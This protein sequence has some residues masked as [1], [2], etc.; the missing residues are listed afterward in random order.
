L[1]SVEFLQIIKRHLLPGGIYYFNTTES[2]DVVLTGL[3]EYRY[4]LRVITF[5][6]IS[7]APIRFDSAHWF[8]VLSRYEIDGKPMFDAGQE[9]SRLVL[10][11]YDAFANTVQEPPRLLGMEAGDQMAVR[12]GKRRIITDDNMGAEW[13]PAPK[14]AWR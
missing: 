8:S 2:P 13:M 6:A 1:L 3:H 14:P 4:G 12:L 5:L 9:R 10:A 11:A 7:D